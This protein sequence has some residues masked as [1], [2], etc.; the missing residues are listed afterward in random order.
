MYRGNPNL[1]DQNESVQ[2]TDELIQEFIKCREDIIYFSE[3]YVRINTQ[4]YGRQLISFK[5]RP[6]QPKILKVF[7]CPDPIK[8]DICILSSRQIGKSVICR[9][10]IAHYLIFNKDKKVGILAHQ[11]KIAK[12]LFEELKML[13]EGLP[14]WLQP[15]VV[16]WNKTS[17]I[18]SNG[19][20]AICASTSSAAIRGLMLNLLILDEFGF[21][22]NH[23]ANKFINSVLP[24]IS[25]GKTGRVV[26]VSTPNG[27]NHFYNIWKKANEDPLNSYFPIKVN[28]WEVPGRDEKW[29]QQQIRSS[30]NGITGFSQEYGA[31]FL[32]SS[33][34]LIEPDVL[35]RISPKDPILFK[36]QD[37][38]LIYEEPKEGSLYYLGVDSAKGTGADFSCIQ[39]IKV[40]D[41]FTIQQVAI[42]R[43]NRIS[44]YN[45]AQICISVSEYY[46]NAQMM[47]ESNGV[48]G[49]VLQSIW[50]EFEY[51]HICNCD[52]VGLGINSNKQNKLSAVINLKEMIEEGFLTVVDQQTL[53]ELSLFVEVS[54]NVFK[55]ESDT[56][57]DDSVTALMWG[58]YVMT[59]LYYDKKNTDVQ[60]VDKQY[61]LT[62]KIEEEEDKPI[63]YFDDDAR[64][65]NFDEKEFNFL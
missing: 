62:K 4:D 43:D 54:Q 10:A 45:F 42:F 18:F 19:S 46:N 60:K 53:Q 35:E 12:E 1:R 39:V 65:G 64:L 63:M 38:L 36:F 47:V 7:Q 27:M 22:P 15:G 59:T 37:R 51:E 30:P 6:Y 56:A 14:L 31:K 49:E 40:V 21:V 34:S 28:W 20:S 48:G 32:G 52:K 13:F 50:Y 57:H 5:D 17:I 61:L 23:I 58:L 2:Y 41:D 24:T 26:I 33:S 29:K 25:S 3:K 11:E 9:I 8:K 55:C 16:E 44:T